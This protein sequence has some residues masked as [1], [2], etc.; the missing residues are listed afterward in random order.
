MFK[1][2]TPLSISRAILALSLVSLVVMMG[3]SM[4]TPSLALYA[5]EYPGANEFLIGAVIAGFAVGRLVFDVPAGFLADRIGISKTMSLGLSVL[6]GSSILAAVAPSYWILLSARIMEG[7]GSAIYVSAAIAFVLLASET[8]RR[9]T[10]MGTYQSILMTGPIV[11]P[12][13]GAPV[14]AYFGLNAPYFAFAAMMAIAFAIVAYLGYRGTFAIEK[15]SA[16]HENGTMGKVGGLSLYVNTAGI[17]TFGFAFLRSGVYSTGLPLFSYGSLSLS[18]FDVGAILTAASLANLAASYFSG[19]LTRLYGMGKPLFAA[20]MSSAVLVALIP[21][22][23]NAWQL[24]VIMMLIGVSSGFFGQSI[25]WAA[26]QIETKV[27]GSRTTETKDNR[28]RLEIGS[29]VTRGIGINRM[30]GDI[31]LILGPLFVGYLVSLFSSDPAAWF[32]S[33]GMTSVTLGLVSLF[34][35]RSVRLKVSNV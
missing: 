1:L 18:L 24:L 21:F 8:S 34:I 13:A 15:P 2:S 30:I 3:S 20:I 9:G 31:G 16:D 6:V 11:G 10:T 22:S 4:A 17:A 5:G 25:A 28:N 35:L 23:T 14:A 26:E 29:H 7:I 12:V 27:R 32:I 19:R 33:F